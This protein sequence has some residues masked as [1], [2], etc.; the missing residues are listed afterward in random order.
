MA[1]VAFALLFGVM[2]VCAR[3]VQ[4]K[5]NAAYWSVSSQGGSG[6]LAGTLIA[7]VQ[8]LAAPAQAAATRTPGGPLFTP[9]PDAP[10][11]LPPLR[12]EVEQ[13]TV[14]ANDTLGTIAQKYGISLGQLIQANTLANPDLVEVGQT[15]TIP[16]PT[17][18]GP[19]P[20]FKIIPD[21]ELVYGPASA[22]F[23]LP[24]FV[25]AQG[26]YLAQYSEEING[27]VLNGAQVVLRVAQDYSVN[28]RLLLALLE[29]QSGWVTHSQPPP[30]T[31]NFPMGLRDQAHKGLYRQLTWTANNLNLGFY[32]WRVGGASTWVL[33]DGSVIPIA[34]TLNAGTAG[35]QN[36]FASL[37]DRP[38]W[39]KAVSPDGLF[40]T[41]NALFGYPFDLAV[42]PL[43]PPGLQQPKM[44]LPFEKGQVWSF[45]GGPHGGWDSGSAWAALDFAPPGD[46]LGC[47]QS[48]A[49]VVAAADGVI[50][51][52]GIGEVI[53]DLDGDG[54]EQTGWVI[55][56]MHIESRDRVK[57]GTAVKAGDRIGHPSCEGG[58]SS[59]THTHIARKYN[60]EWIPADQNLPFVLDGWVSHGEGYQYEGYLQKGSK[61]IEAYAGRAQDNGIS[62]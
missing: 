14:Q 8:G 59:G 18:E 49:W 21:S 28:P 11:A 50:L 2:L 10:H 55:F 22:S 26:G 17:P 33:A 58:V 46:A 5:D 4:Q 25:Q 27:E 23:D 13:Y 40:A 9:T 53:E 56:Y 31:S 20:D 16:V 24:G 39:E 1:L 57:P 37:Y 42:E 52:T 48:D 19:G 3:Y 43:I 45:T 35:V 7:P 38:N 41:Y 47:V 30:G 51:R 44:Q 61:T 15:L 32:L 12:S 60:G 62:R 34:P 54:L 29:Y 6:S 36:L